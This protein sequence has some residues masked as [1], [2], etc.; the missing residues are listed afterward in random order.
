MADLAARA[1]EY[2]DVPSTLYFKYKDAEALQIYGLNRGENT[3]QSSPEW[4]AKSWTTLDNT[5]IQ[6]LYTN[7]PNT[8]QFWPIWKVFI[9]GSNGTLTNDYGY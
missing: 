2:A 5:K 9:D 6:S 1:G 7:D 8:K 4:T 3:P